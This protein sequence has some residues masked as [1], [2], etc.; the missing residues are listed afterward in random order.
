MSYL[1][2]LCLY[3]YSGFQHICCGFALFFLVFDRS[4]FLLLL[5]Y[6]LTFI[7]VMYMFQFCRRYY[8]HKIVVNGIINMT[9]ISNQNQI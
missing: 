6:Y 1:R 7:Y 5:R 9:H 8:W 4:V 3:V 2:Y